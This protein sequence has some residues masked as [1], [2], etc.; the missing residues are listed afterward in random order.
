MKAYLD[1]ISPRHIR[2]IQEYAAGKDLAEI[3]REE[4]SSRE[5]IFANFKNGSVQT[6]RMW[7]NHRAYLARR[8]DYRGEGFTEDSSGSSQRRSDDLNIVKIMNIAERIGY[9]N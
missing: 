4:K 6:A 1:R 9:M 3:A 8:E 2:V 5:T 7:R